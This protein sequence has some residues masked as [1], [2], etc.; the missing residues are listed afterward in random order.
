MFTTRVNKNTALH[1]DKGR[2]LKV[3]IAQ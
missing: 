3:K 1:H 2:S